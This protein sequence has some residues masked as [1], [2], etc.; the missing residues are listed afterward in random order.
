MQFN[1]HELKAKAGKPIT[2]TLKHVGK[3][4]VKDMGHNIVIIKPGTNFNDF[5]NRAAKDAADDYIPK[6]DPSIVAHTKLLG[7]GEQD[8][9]TFTINEKGTYEYLCTFPAHSATM[10]GKLIVE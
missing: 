9:I 10:R 1:I 3:A 8:T 7:G 6:N 5:A 4:S 2:L